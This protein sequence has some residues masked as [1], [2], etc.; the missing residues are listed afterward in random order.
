MKMILLALSIFSLTFSANFA[1]ADV[2]LETLVDFSLKASVTGQPN[3]VS[4]IN[5][6]QPAA[7]YDEANFRE[8][9]TLFMGGYCRFEIVGPISS[10]SVPKGTVFK[11]VGDTF[12][13]RSRFQF[14]ILRRSIFDGPGPTPNLKLFVLCYG[15]DASHLTN[16][17]VANTLSAL[18]KITY[19]P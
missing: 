3:F 13:E 11:M 1:K 17:V 16:D 14:K 9:F 2:T 6:N 7:I 19:I 8:P 18:G 12:R 4:F 5:L 10:M 15:E